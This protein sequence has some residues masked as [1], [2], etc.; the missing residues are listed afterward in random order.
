[1][2]VI[3]TRIDYRTAYFIIQCLKTLTYLLTYW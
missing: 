3:E 2:I 1:M